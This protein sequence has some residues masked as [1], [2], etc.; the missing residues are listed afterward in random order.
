MS[1]AAEQ[2]DPR[3]ANFEGSLA[4]ELT[5]S[6]SK[7]NDKIFYFVVPKI[8]AHFVTKAELRKYLE[9]Q[10][11]SDFQVLKGRALETRVNTIVKFDVL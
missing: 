2:L 8:D 6:E 5:Q 4:N 1:E 7:A 10:G 3:V 9:A 11:R